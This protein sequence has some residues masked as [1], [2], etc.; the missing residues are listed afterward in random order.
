MRMDRDL[1][2]AYICMRMD[3]DMLVAYICVRMD[4]DLLIT[5]ASR[6][7]H[8]IAILAQDVGIFDNQT[9]REHFC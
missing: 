7:K 4:Q 1:L 9:P 3:R 2:V 8:Q 6:P 5:K